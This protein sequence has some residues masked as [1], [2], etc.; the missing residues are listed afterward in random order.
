MFHFIE[1]WSMS[2]AAA[3]TQIAALRAERRESLEVFGLAIGVPSKGRVSEIERGIRSVTQAQALAIEELSDGR[4]DAATL[5]AEVAAARA[6]F[7]R[8]AA[9]EDVA[10]VDHSA[11]S[12]TFDRIVLCAICTRR[13][14]DPA[15]R[16]CTEFDCPHS[17]RFA[18]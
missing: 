6:G 17:E 4:I 3:H 9:N 8:V 13:T 18:A 16:S 5:N 2:K 7:E 10:D 1:L 11:R 15:V 12:E 14:D